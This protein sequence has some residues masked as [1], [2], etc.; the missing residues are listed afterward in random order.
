LNLS[1]LKLVLVGGKICG[2][3][4]VLSPQKMGPKITNTQIAYTQIA[5]TNSPQIANPQIAIFAEGSQI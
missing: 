4:E 5:K 1:S 2:F 3:A